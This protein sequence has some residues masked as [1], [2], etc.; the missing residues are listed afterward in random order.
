MQSCSSQSR[1]DQPCSNPARFSLAFGKQQ[2][3]L[4]PREFKAVFD[5]ALHKISHRSLLLLA[6]PGAGAHSR[7][8]LVVAKKNAK[9][10]VQRNRLKR[11]LRESF[12]HHQHELQG[13]DIVALV[14]PGLWQ[15]SNVEINAV[16]DQQWQRLLKSMQKEQKLAAEQPSNPQ[17]EVLA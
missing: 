9:L 17:Q 3:L 12:R 14:K 13:V 15:M 11:L 1:S 16:I 5:C 2:R 6:I 8:G 4:T 10:A 7:L